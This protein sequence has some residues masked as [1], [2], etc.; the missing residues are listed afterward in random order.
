MMARVRKQRKPRPAPTTP[1]QVLLDEHLEKLALKNYTEDTLKVRRVHVEMFLKWAAERGLT[2]PIEI[3]RPVLER[4]QRYLFHYRKKDGMPLSFGSQHSRLTPL[5]VWFKWMTRQNYILHNPASELELPRLGF[6]LPSV[7]NQE[8]AELVLQQ[9]NVA[10]PIGLRDRAILET[11]Y[12]T[13]MRRTELRQIKLPELDRSNGIVTIR[14]GKGK[15]DR[16][17][18]IGERAIAWIDK[19]L[20]EV[21]AHLVVEPD[22]GTV[23]LTSTGEPFHPNHLS[24][25][26]RSYVE[27]AQIGKSGACHL[28]RHTAATLM[29]EGGAD[30]RFI[31]QMLGHSRLDTTQIYTHVSIR[32]LKQI[33]AAT[34]PGAPLHHHGQAPAVPPVVFREEPWPSAPTREELLAALA[35]ENDEED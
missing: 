29:L 5:R 23:F 13:G 26:A 3:T 21:R 9:P 33:H 16:V 18:P 2:E 28:F 25:M 27:Q 31:Q 15:K 20:S 10:D 30:I 1:L 32:M 7:L 24:A 14:E 11:F 6:H 22:D 4:Y 12:S 8:E 17:I 34:H 19:Y 35:A